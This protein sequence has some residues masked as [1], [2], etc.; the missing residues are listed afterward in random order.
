MTRPSLRS[1]EIAERRYPLLHRFLG[2]YLHQGWPE[3]HGSAEGAI[4]DAIA[5]YSDDLRSKVRDE[6]AGLA[7]EV[8]DD[9]DLR[10]A[11]NDGFD[12]CVHFPKPRAARA[13][14]E[15]AMGKLDHSLQAAVVRIV[16]AVAMNKRG[17]TLLVRKRGTEAFMQPGGKLNEGEAPV[18]ALEREIAEELG[19]GIADARPLGTFVA[20]AANEPD[21][22]VEAQLY[23]VTL[24]GEPCA[25]AE[26]EELIWLDPDADPPYRLAP[27][28]RIHA[29]RL[30]RGLKG[31]FR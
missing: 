19:C 8:S 11:L 5:D 16:A 10:A 9:T 1:R 20:E 13:F 18:T 29:L 15:M 4:A 31:D 25:Q 17:E 28:T 27:L 22:V 24:S 2:G 12:V 23:A 21:T 14:V 6:L 30:A 7:T 26:I 3:L